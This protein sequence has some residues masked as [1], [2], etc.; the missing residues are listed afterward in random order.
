MSNTKAKPTPI[1]PRPEAKPTAQSIGVS[2]PA[3]QGDEL[4]TPRQIE[5]RTRA[6]RQPAGL[7]RLKP[8]PCRTLAEIRAELQARDQRAERAR[9]IGHLLDT[10]TRIPP[11][12]RGALKRCIITLRT[13]DLSPAQN[14]LVND[15]LVPYRKPG[16]ELAEA[17]AEPVNITQR[18]ITEIELVLA[19]GVDGYEHWTQAMVEAL[20]DLKRGIPLD[21]QMRGVHAHYHRKYV[22]TGGKPRSGYGR[23]RGPKK[24]K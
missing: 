3:E 22:N 5:A 10:S 13:K 6:Q 23:G 8:G 17:N 1:S 11:D 4:L 18:T 20:H 14:K 7:V 15:F 9:E 21:D 24:P 16:T 2:I 19:V 12:L